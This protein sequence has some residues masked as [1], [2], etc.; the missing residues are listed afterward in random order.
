MAHKLLVFF[1]DRWYHCLAHYLGSAA[2]VWPGV[3]KTAKSKFGSI[4]WF[5]HDKSVTAPVFLPTMVHEDFKSCSCSWKSWV[6][7]R[8]NM[9]VESLNGVKPRILPVIDHAQPRP[10]LE[11]CAMNA[12]WKLSRNEVEELAMLKG[13]QPPNGIPFV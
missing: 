11:T 3:L 6:W 5:I 7:Q 1:D 9:P 8:K 4:N 2:I 13:I 10:L 12:F